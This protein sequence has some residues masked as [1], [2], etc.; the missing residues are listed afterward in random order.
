MLP[1][2][3]LL[4]GSSSGNGNIYRFAADGTLSETYASGLGQIGGIATVPEPGT[5]WLGALGLS[6]GAW[7]LRR[8]RP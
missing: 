3:D 7:F 2:G 5:L 6:V 1:D 4:A 8:R